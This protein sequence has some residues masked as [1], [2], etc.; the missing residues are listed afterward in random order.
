MVIMTI[1]LDLKVFKR[2]YNKY[3]YKINE[4]LAGSVDHSYFY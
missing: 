4:Y 3:I 2:K 1:K